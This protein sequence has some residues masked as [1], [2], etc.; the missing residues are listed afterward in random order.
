M[1]DGSGGV[2]FIENDSNVPVD[3]NACTA[4][5]CTAGVPSNPD[6]GSGTACGSGSASL[7]CNG[8]GVCVGCNVASDCPGSDTFCAV[9]SC[10]D[11]ACGSADTA[12]GTQLPPAD[13]PSG[14]CQELVCDGSGNTT[15]QE[16][17]ANVPVDGNACTQDLC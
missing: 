2:I 8:S 7:V 15:S 6:L 14:T 4:D 3:G 11:N 12:A 16:D 17:D 13:Q 1:C 5:V 10:S 9:R